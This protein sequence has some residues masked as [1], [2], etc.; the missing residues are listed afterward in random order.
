MSWLPLTEFFICGGRPQGICKS[1]SRAIA[2]ANARL[3]AEQHRVNAR[4]WYAANPERTKARITKWR[5]AN[6]ERLIEHNR[7]PAKRAKSREYMRSRIG[8]EEYRAYQRAYK[9]RTGK[10]T[11]D[12]AE[13][14]ARVRNATVEKVSRHDV[15][16]RDGLI[17]Y[18]CAI[19]LTWDSATLDHVIPLARGGSH[20]L[21]NLRVCCGTCNRR[22]H[23]RTLDEYRAYLRIQPYDVLP[24]WPVPDPAI[25]VSRA[26]GLDSRP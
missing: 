10:G 13:R 20:S 4:R 12:K 18:L 15:I 23:T 2:L 3:N 24:V 5:T 9:K 21:D 22:K 7:T 26:P 1:D 14:R 11:T 16:T 25:A 6:P 17:C 8:T 19:T